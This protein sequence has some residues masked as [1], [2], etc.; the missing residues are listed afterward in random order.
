MNSLSLCWV[1]KT[2]S[3]ILLNSLRAVSDVRK[4]RHWRL[5][6]SIIPMN[7]RIYFCLLTILFKS[8]TAYGGEYIALA[9]SSDKLAWTKL[10]DSVWFAPNAGKEN[11]PGMYVYR[12]KF[13]K[14]YKNEPHYHTDERVVTVLSGSIY[15]GFGEELKE[16]EMVKLSAGGVYTEPRRSPHYVWVKDSEVI[17]QVV[18]TGSS[19]RVSINSNVH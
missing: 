15:V 19:K 18:G 5:S 8:A 16:S 6:Q 13:E 11:T 14:G 12:V 1:A 2:S 10:G 7:Y 17:L 4:V 3:Q 9:V